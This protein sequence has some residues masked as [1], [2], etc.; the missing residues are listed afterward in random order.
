[1]NLPFRGAG[2][3]TSCCWKSHFSCSHRLSHDLQTDKNHLNKKKECFL[4]PSSEAFPQQVGQRPLFQWQLSCIH[5]DLLQVMSKPRSRCTQ[6]ATPISRGCKM[7]V[8]L[9]LCASSTR[10]GIQPVRKHL[11]VPQELG[12]EACSPQCWWIYW[13]CHQHKQRG[14][15]QLPSL[16]LALL[17]LL[18]REWLISISPPGEGRKGT[19]PFS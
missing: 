19:F 10:G 16:Q 13:N 14:S 1:M 15:S 6:T 9:G 3:E 2:I 18:G 8:C 12:G 17:Q 7:R 11:P 5:P 4:D